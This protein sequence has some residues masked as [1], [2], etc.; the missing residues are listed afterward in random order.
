MLALTPA[1]RIFVAVAPVDFDLEQD[2]AE[3]GAELLSAVRGPFTS[4][5]P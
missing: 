3:L 2:S 4:H 1:T 5:G